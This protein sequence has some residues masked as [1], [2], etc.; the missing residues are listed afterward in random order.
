MRRDQKKE[1]VDYKRPDAERKQ[2]KELKM[3]RG[4]RCIIS[5]L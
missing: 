1:D 4:M 2:T 3:G 5:G